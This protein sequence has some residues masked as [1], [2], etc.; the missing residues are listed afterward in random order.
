MV[1]QLCSKCSLLLEE[2]RFN[3]QRYCKCCHAQY[4]RQTRKKYSELSS[5]QK[6]KSNARSYLH[7][8]IKRNKVQKSFC[9]KCDAPIAEAHHND[10]S[11]PLE[12]VWLCRK[13]HLEHHRNTGKN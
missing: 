11:K 10:Y 7:S 4:M 12:I 3:K 5:E 1:K 8:Y 2:N 13:C 9:F 6:M